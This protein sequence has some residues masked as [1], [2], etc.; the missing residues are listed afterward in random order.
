MAL[1]LRPLA[2]RLVVAPI[3]THDGMT[4]AKE[5][6]L[7]ELFQDMGAQLLTLE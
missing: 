3:I 6:E 7:E 4:V 1:K 5:I 2:D